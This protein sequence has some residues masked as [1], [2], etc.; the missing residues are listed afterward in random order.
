M[1][2]HAGMTFCTFWLWVVRDRL[3]TSVHA[4]ISLAATGLLQ[5]SVG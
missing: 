1:W 5:L 2:N 4:D 3:M